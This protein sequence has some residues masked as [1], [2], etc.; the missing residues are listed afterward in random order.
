MKDEQNINEEG[1][2]V[3]TTFASE[4]FTHKEVGAGNYY[5]SKE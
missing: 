5:L 4:K 3:S 2:D 1:E